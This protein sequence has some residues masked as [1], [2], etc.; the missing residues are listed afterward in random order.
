MLLVLKDAALSRLAAFSFAFSAMQMCL[1]AYLVTYLNTALG[2]SL[3]AAGLA[4]SVAQAGGVIG[5]VLWGYVA[6]RWLGAQRML[7]IVAAIMAVC[8]LGTAGLQAGVPQPLVLALLGAFGASATGW[9][10]VYLAEVA[11]LSPPGMASAATG[12]SLAI[13]FFGVVLG[14]LLFGAISGAFGSYRAG[15]IAFAIPVALSAWQLLR[16]AQREP[17]T[18]PEGRPS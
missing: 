2:Y 11:R 5:R 15:Y 12:G 13:T 9:N 4:L 8:A 3:L 7:A 6:D 14:P 17:L 16:M 10:G 18:P 1:A